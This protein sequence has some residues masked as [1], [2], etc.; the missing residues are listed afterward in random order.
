MGIDALTRNDAGIPAAPASPEAWEDWVSATRLRGYLLK[1][2]LGDWLDMYGEANGFQRDETSEDYDERL[3]FAPFIMGRGGRFEQAVSAHLA[4]FHELTTISRLREDVRS[5]EV[6]QQTFQA[7][8]EGRPIIHQAVLWNPESRTY[9]AADFLIRSDVFDALFPGHLAPGEAAVSA[10]DLG[11]PWHYIVVDAKF[12]TVRLA[13][14]GELGESN[15][16]PAYRGQFFVYNDALARLQ[17]YAPRRA[18]LLGRGWEQGSERGFSAM[19]RLG[20]VPM[21]ADLRGRVEAAAA[22]I[23]RLRAEGAQWSPLP[24]PTVQEL[25]PSAQDWP[26]ENAAKRIVEE[27]EDLTQLWQVGTEKRNNAVRRGITSW[28]DTR[29]TAASLG[30]TGQV[31]Q[32]V[33]E[34]IL[35][36]HRNDGPVVRPARVRAEESEWRKPPPLEF[37]VDFEYVSD[38]NDDFSSFPQRGGQPIIFMIGCGHVEDGAW[39]FAQFTADR[40]DE[41]GEERTIDAWL[42]HMRETQSRLGGG[43]EPRLFHWAPAEEINYETA[44]NSARKRHPAKDWPEVNWFDLMRKVVR[45]EPVV[46]HGAMGFGLKAVARAFHGHGLIETGWGSSKVDG[47]GAMVGAWRCDEEAAERGVRLKDTPLMQDIAEY[48]EVDCKVMME[49]LRYLR[50]YH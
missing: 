33:L 18:F 7:L 31:Y 5:L 25:W 26:W 3:V 37:F 34:A 2:T 16:S 24:R 27:L 43:D 41:A 35:D 47:M 21:S 29:A 49:I 15:S 38:L 39:R 8:A 44:Y 17:G 28:R 11:G 6:A 30:V 45:K 14:H 40:L 13:R 12:T 46:V 42:A 9:G 19:E 50:A 10:P 4:S 22:W 23:R 32:R 48:N 1:N 20:P 36:V